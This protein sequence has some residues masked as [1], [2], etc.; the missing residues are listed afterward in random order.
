[1]SEF[2]T[3]AT[4]DVQVSSSSIRSARSDIE[5]GLG[6]VTVGP[7]STTGSSGGSGIA[8]TNSHLEDNLDLN[9]ERNDLLRQ[10][11]DVN[12]KRARQ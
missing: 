4:I 9:R 10:L 2:S 12:E 5:D 8:E 3:S 7:S 6:D 1:M 11:V